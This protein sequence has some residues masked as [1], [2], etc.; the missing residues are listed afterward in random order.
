MRSEIYSTLLLALLCG[1]S[2]TER[3][4]SFFPL[5]QIQA[6]I[7]DQVPIV[8]PASGNWS[9]RIVQM[10]V[11]SPQEFAGMLL[12]IRFKTSDDANYRLL[13]IPGG[14]RFRLDAPK[15]EGLLSGEAIHFVPGRHFKVTRL[16]DGP[17]QTA[18]Q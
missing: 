7:D 12:V 3:R 4:S 2:S 1:C 18:T 14:G 11:I 8:L 6:E 17:N 15:G 5:R 9:S 16:N 10:R 13:S